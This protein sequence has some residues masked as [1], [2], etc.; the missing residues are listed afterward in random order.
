MN[1]WP[2]WLASASLRDRH[3]NIV[4]ALKWSRDTTRRV[5]DSLDILLD[6]TG[7]PKHEREFRMCI[8]LCRHRALS[9]AEYD[10]LPD[11]FHEADAVDIAGGPV[12]VLWRRGLDNTP[13]TQPCANPTRRPIGIPGLWFPED[14]GKCVSCR[15]R[16]E[17][18]NMPGGRMV[19]PWR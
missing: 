13:G 2:V 3:G 9:Q 1:G 12:E 8:T 11:W 5:S 17:V 7:D 6:G 18:R 19:R 4:S 10:A 14:C 15:A 16:D